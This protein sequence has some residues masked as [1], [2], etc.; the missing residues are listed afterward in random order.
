MRRL[1]SSVCHNGWQL[2][3]AVIHSRRQIGG[4]QGEGG[5]TKWDRPAV[6]NVSDDDVYVTRTACV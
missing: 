1:R 6:Y 3:W 5:E 2:G 4:G